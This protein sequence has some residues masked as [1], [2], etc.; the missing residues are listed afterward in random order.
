MNPQDWKARGEK[1]AAEKGKTVAR[2]ALPAPA[3][4]LAG[5]GGQPPGQPISAEAAAAL[6]EHHESSRLWI[7]DGNFVRPIKVKIIATDGTMTEVR[8]QDVVE[9]MDIAIGES[10]VN[11]ADSGDTTNPFMPKLFKGNPNSKSSGSS[12]K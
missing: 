12:K 11:E 3:A 6:K 9:G 2:P 5:G 1:N 7:V 8:G 10:V 4:K